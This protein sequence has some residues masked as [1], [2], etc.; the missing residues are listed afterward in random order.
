MLG[1]RDP[2]S[3]GAVTP[4]Y[5]PAGKR[6]L[7]DNGTWYQTLK[8]PHIRVL[9]DRIARFT[10]GAWKRKAGRATTLTW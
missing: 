4:H 7:V 6:M 3:L 2:I 10:E 8:L 1:D 5:P 9:T